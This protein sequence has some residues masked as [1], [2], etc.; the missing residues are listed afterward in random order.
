MITDKN[1][2]TVTSGAAK[3]SVGTALKIT[4]QP[5]NQNGTVGTDVKFTVTATGD[6]LTYQWQYSTNGTSWSNTSATGCKAATLTVPAT[7]SRNGYQY[8]CV[9]TDKNKNT[10][11]SGAA[12]LS[13]DPALKITTQPAGKTAKDGE[14]A[15]FKVTAQG[16][17]LTYQ[18]QYRASSTAKW[19][20]TTATG[21]K[22]A[23]LTIAVT[24][25]KNGYQYQ[26]II[27]DKYGASVTSNAATLTVSKPLKITAQPTNKTVAAGTDAKFTVTATGT[28][29]TYQWQYRTSATAKWNNT[30]ATGCKTAT[31]TVA[32]TAAKNGYQYQC[33]IKDSSGA[34]VTTK[35]AT[36]T[37]Q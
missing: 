12:K 24:N 30:S 7:T 33:I 18:W 36:L 26:C 10:V 17:G 22:T 23:S 14:N 16:G 15:V 1:K 3:L 9:I 27:K 21:C 31:L 35:E 37:V 19:T 32:T 34:S 13:V 25:A 28:G 4:A 6:G 29:L 5:A 8:R 11:T 2:N 20:N